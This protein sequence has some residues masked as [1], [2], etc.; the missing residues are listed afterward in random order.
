[1]TTETDKQATGGA[2]ERKAAALLTM[3]VCA[4]TSHGTMSEDGGKVDL[5][6]SFRSH[7]RP[8]SVITAHCQ[9]KSGESFRAHTSTNELLKLTV[10]SETLDALAEGTQP[11]FVAWVSPRPHG[12][13]YWQSVQSRR[14]QKTVLTVPPYQFVTPSLRLDLSRVHAFRSCP[15]GFPVINLPANFDDDLKRART[16]YKDLKAEP[17]TSPVV[18][19]MRFTRKG[20]RHVTRRSRD[21]AKTLRSFRLLPYLRAL[22][23]TSPNRFL[24]VRNKPERIGTRTRETREVIIWF[25]EVIKDNGKPCDVLMRLDERVEYPTK[26]S[27]DGLA[28]SEVEV[29]TT[30]KSWWYKPSKPG[31]KK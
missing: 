13:I 21:T 5:K 20:W 27:R 8:S 1:M 11:A 3:A 30:V 26:W 12:R 18:G 23:R 16:H 25:R 9:V 19:E 15:A 6:L 28:P 14:K 31:L 2:G 29:T 10:D 22:L 24:V 4:Q 17:V 7:L